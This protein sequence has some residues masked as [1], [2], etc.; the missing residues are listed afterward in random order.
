MLQIPESKI[1]RVLDGD[2]EAATAALQEALTITRRYGF[3]YLEVQCCTLLGGVAGM[4]GDHRTPRRATSPP[5]PCARA[6]RRARRVWSSPCA[7]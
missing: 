1:V 5:R 2:Q 3:N 4:T 6:G 7:P